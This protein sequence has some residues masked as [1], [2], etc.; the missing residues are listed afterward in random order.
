MIQLSLIPY[1]AFTIRRADCGFYKF[2][3]F[4]NGNELCRF[5]GLDTAISYIKQQ[6][7]KLNYPYKQ[8]IS[9]IEEVIRDFRIYDDAFNAKEKS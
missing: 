2:T 8:K 7:N 5:M 9:I 3:V 4:L 1:T 6:L